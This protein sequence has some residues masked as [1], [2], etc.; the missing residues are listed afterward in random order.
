MTSYD[1]NG[2]VISDAEWYAQHNTRVQQTGQVGS[3]FWL[4]QGYQGYDASTGMPIFGNTTNLTASN[5]PPDSVKALYTDANYAA[6]IVPALINNVV[7]K[8]SQSGPVSV[9]PAI[10]AKLD[11]Y[12]PQQV[13]T[14]SNLPDSVV[15]GATVLPD[16]SGITTQLAGGASAV[17][18]F[19]EKNLIWIIV[20][21][22][23]IF[24]SLRALSMAAH[25]FTAPV[26]RSRAFA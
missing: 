14:A 3:E 4:D 13:S 2:N 20:G 23:I 7:Q 12:A 1:E 10:Q 19:I 5:Q 11:T 17:V 25:G 24:V 9:S 6:S 15:S 21:L 18:G 16:L 26:R 8:A 22:V